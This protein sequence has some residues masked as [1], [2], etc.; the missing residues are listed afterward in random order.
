[1]TGVHVG[2]IPAFGIGPYLD[3][4]A[5]EKVNSTP[6]LERQPAAAIAPREAGRMASQQSVFTVHHKKTEPLE[7]Y[8]DR[9]HLWRLVIP[10][11]SK[12]AI[13]EQL[14]TLGISRLSVFPDLDSVGQL[15][16]EAIHE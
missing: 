1:M 2:D 14:A 10:A 9:S 16:T 4:Y 8:G 11:A 13:R 5:P 3:D 7:S 15:A 12:S 6:G